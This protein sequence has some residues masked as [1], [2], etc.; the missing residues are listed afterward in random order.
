MTNHVKCPTCGMTASETDHRLL[1]PSIP[2]HEGQDLRECRNCGAVLDL[3]SETYA[4]LAESS[5]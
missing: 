4:G 5:T 3:A 1:K 2:S